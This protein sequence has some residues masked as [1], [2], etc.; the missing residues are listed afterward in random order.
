MNSP[1][2]LT[3]RSHLWAAAALGLALLLPS[4]ADLGPSGNMALVGG[5][6][7]VAVG[8]SGD[9]HGAAAIARGTMNAINDYNS[10]YSPPADPCDAPDYQTEGDASGGYPAPDDYSDDLPDDDETEDEIIAENSAE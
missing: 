8:A 1:H 7:S 9:H 3:H 4:C 6:A 5:L 10:S 2:S